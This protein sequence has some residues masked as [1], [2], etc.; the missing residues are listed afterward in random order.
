MSGTASEERYS[1]GS[2]SGR[3]HV[4]AHGLKSGSWEFYYRS[5]S[6]K[7]TGEFVDGEMSGDWVW[8]R[9]DGTL[10]RTGSF[11]AGTQRGLWKTYDGAGVLVRTTDFH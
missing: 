11:V 8:T 6:L 10:M 9:E 4:D 2:I 3:G 5:G 1:D 7:G